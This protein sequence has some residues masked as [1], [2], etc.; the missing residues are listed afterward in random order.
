MT[1]LLIA[2]VALTAAGPAFA[3]VEPAAPVGPRIEAHIG[4]DRP[5][6]TINGQD[7][8]T[9][10]RGSGSTSGVTYGGE[11]GYDF[12]AGQY[13]VLGVYGGV[14]GASTK[15]CT[16]VYGGDEACLKAGRNIAVGV[17]AGYMVGRSGLLY[18]KGGYSNGRI[19]LTYRDP[20]F[21]ADNFDDGFNRD[22]FH[23]GAGAEYGFGR[24]VYAKVEYDYT[25]YNSVDVD[26]GVTSGSL[27]FDR[28]QVI[29]GLGVRF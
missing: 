19:R 13:A 14:D 18:V 24:N 6:L 28:H 20:A 23:L 12:R 4:W 22:G 11:V 17:R 5:V 8:T 3:Q 2:A 9:S 10:V 29:G 26:D 15:A 25:N 1:K 27:D 21:P 7:A 16:D